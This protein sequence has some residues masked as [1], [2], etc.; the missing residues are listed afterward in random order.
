MKIFPA[1]PSVSD[2]RWRGLEAR[3]A[4]GSKMECTSA[5]PDRIQGNDN[6]KFTQ[7]PSW[8]FFVTFN[9]TP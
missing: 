6:N 5:I 1:Q 8:G 9:K 2:V 4:M 3:R 7:A